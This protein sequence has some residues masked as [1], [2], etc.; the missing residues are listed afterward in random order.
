MKDFKF[1]NI[2]NLVFHFAVPD[3]NARK[4]FESRGV[5]FNLCCVE[6]NIVFCLPETFVFSTDC[7]LLE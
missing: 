5:L 1:K 2:C 3:R 4:V 6:H 7:P